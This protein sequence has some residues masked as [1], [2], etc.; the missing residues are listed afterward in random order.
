M[1]LAS[2]LGW[3]IT[4]YLVFLNSFFLKRSCWLINLQGIHRSVAFPD[5]CWQQTVLPEGIAP[6]AFLTAHQFHLVE[7]LFQTEQFSADSWCR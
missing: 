4:T 2:P 7:G 1:V 5:P 6:S 3:G